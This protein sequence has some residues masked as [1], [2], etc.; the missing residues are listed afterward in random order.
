M[1]VEMRALR[2]CVER[3]RIGTVAQVSCKCKNEDSSLENEG[4]S[5]HSQEQS[6]IQCDSDAL[7][8]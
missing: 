8:A 3:W 5:A 1:N 4:A 7:L 2:A 6:P